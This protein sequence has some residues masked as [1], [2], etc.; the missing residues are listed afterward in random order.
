MCHP[1]KDVNR[2]DLKMCGYWG[3]PQGECEE[4][5]CCW[6]ESNEV[7]A[8]ECFKPPAQSKF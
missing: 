1:I 2:E 4:Q 5:G 6:I 7:N 3:I 8:D